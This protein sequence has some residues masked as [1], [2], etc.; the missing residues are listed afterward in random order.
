MYLRCRIAIGAILLALAAAVIF[1]FG[2][3][4]QQRAVVLEDG[5]LVRFVGAVPGGAP[6]TNEKPWHQF[7]REHLPAR[8][9][10]WIPPSRTMSC[11]PPNGIS[12]YFDWVRKYSA[13]D[14]W[15]FRSPVR[16][17]AVDEGGFVYK[18]VSASCWSH[19]N[20]NLTLLGLN[21]RQFPR[22]QGQFP[23][24]IY[25][26][27]DE[28]AARL[29]V[30]NPLPRNFPQWTASP[31]PVTNVVQDL[32]IVLSGFSRNT[33]AYSSYWRPR[34]VLSRLDGEPTQMRL[35][36][37]QFIDPTGN[38]G[39]ELSP[40]EPVW[41]SELKLY[42]PIDGEFDSK[43]KGR[44]AG[45]RVPDSGE[46]ELHRPAMVVD[47]LSFRLLF[48]SGPGSITTSNGVEFHAEAL[49]QPMTS[50]SEWHPRRRLELPE[51]PLKKLQQP[52]ASDSEWHSGSSSSGFYAEWESKD[53]LIVIETEDPGEDVEFLFRFIDQEGR[54]IWPVDESNWHGGATFRAPYGRRYTIALELGEDSERLDVECIV[55][56]GLS[57]GFFVN[58]ADLLAQPPQSN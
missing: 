14:H 58:S 53:H 34:L 16:V 41:L 23:L 17:E 38:Q 4:E 2:R 15:T 30:N 50:D 12:V 27:R 52:M 43:S 11:G 47:D 39:F 6:F 21:L 48:F 35:R 57:V 13:G 40:S 29:L 37:Y 3:R 19:L 31:L 20:G 18:N 32:Q 7:L 28:L 42:R 36:R 46:I 44:F 33:G 55:N 24:L 22:R 25:N 51:R 10:R 1:W 49:Q 54:R 45:L 56:R 8:W 9:L 5:S 26:H